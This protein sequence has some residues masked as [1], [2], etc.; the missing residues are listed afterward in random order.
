[1][2]VNAINEPKRIMIVIGTLAVGG[3]AEKVAATIG[4]EL[5]KRGHD[6]HLVTFYEA[7]QKYPFMG[8]YYTFGEPLISNRLRKIWR[9]PLRVAALRRYVRTH[10]IDTAVSFLE[11]ANFYTLLAK[12]SGSFSLPVIV[13]VRNNIEKREWPFKLMTRLLYPFAK[14]VVSVTKAVE[15]TLKTKY[16]LR[17]TVTIYNPLDMELINKSMNCSIPADYERLFAEKPLCITIGRLTHQ[18]GQWHLIRA[19]T[20]VQK[21]FVG[22]KLVI[23]GEGEYRDRLVQLV[24]GCGLSDTVHLIGNHTNVYRFLA[25][26]DLFVFSSLWEGMP[27]TMLEAL[28]VGLPIVSPDC[29]SGPREIIAPEVAVSTSVTYPFVTS[30]GVLT[31]PLTTEAIWQPPGTVPLTAEEQQLAKAIIEQL[32]ILQKPSRGDDGASGEL[33]ERA[34][35]SRTFDHRF[36][37]SRIIQEW[38]NEINV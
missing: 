22:A 25:R 4:T 32:K 26:S 8:T 19:F 2:A 20:E 21:I 33:A 11:E 38:E 36:T 9:I 37:L 18:K 27:N 34:V 10:K 30:T 6:V 12:L 16:G 23:I 28:S 15:E 3:G 29:V 17:N 7:A 31:A 24:S 5:T 13:S 1:M 14:K 35:P